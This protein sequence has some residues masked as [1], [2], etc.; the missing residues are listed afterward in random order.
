M[1]Q[2]APRQFNDILERMINRVVART[3]LND[4]NDGS[5]VKQVLAA[6]SREDDDQYYQMVNLLDLSTW[7]SGRRSSIPRWSPG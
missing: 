6:A 1:G 7:T 3:D 2:F 4:I 5:S